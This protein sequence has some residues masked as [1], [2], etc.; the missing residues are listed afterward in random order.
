M[1]IR[2]TT[3]VKPIA[4]IVQEADDGLVRSF[5]TEMLQNDEE[6]ALRFQM[7]A[8]PEISEADMT[9]YYHLVDQIA[10]DSAGRDGFI[11]YYEA[12]AFTSGMLDI[13]HTHVGE[14]MKKGSLTQAFDLAAHVFLVAAEVDMDDSDGGLTDIAMSCRD[15]WK[16][17]A[18]S[19]DAGIIR[20]LLDWCFS[21]LDGSVVDYMEEHIEGFLL[22]TRAF[23][24]A[25]YLPELLDFTEKK[26][27]RGRAK[28][29]DSW[30]DQ[31]AM[32]FWAA[33]HLK[34][35]KK[36][37]AKEE[38]IDAYARKYWECSDVRAL[39]IARYE[40]RKDDAA[41]EKL[42]LECCEIDAKLPGLVA[43]YRVKLKD[44][45]R[46]TRRREEYLALLRGLIAKAHPAEML[47]LFLELKGQFSQEDWPGEREK[48]YRA[49]EPEKLGLLYR[50][51]R[52][53]DLLLDFVMKSSGL[54]EAQT[55]QKDLKK[56]YPDEL[57]EKYDQELER[58]AQSARDRG[59]YR[60]LARHMS[61]MK[62]IRGGAEKVEAIRARW[63]KAYAHR[64]AMLDEIGKA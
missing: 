4:K 64:P 16:K 44:L 61:S 60:K 53:F 6:L 56:L 10:E 45:Y 5:L 43:G 63:R 1:T 2:K 17:I 31:R 21:H 35:M 47:I 54:Y 33:A 26:A 22:D 51:E 13:L 23:Q 46:R 18:A 37:R 39:Y 9:R 24:A 48:L 11:D 55:Y 7:L 41:L 8:A 15:I 36:G 52:Q 34:L 20:H 62:K 3:R 50:E 12:G 40:R 32:G 58:M 49:I 27:A 38:D 25:E 57:L 19:K 28:K 29:A 14:L 59:S 42:L 30:S